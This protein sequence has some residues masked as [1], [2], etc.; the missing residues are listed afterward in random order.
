MSSPH[1]RLLEVSTLSGIEED[2][3][4]QQGLREPELDNAIDLRPLSL[5]VKK[6]FTRTMGGSTVLGSQRSENSRS[7]GRDYHPE[8]AAMRCAS[9]PLR[10]FGVLPPCPAV[11]EMSTE[12]SATLGD[13]VHLQELS[14]LDGCY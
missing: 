9:I 2:K 7:L 3:P 5:S 1:C 12:T 4:K 11:Q 13:S 6:L 14:E 8:G 10:V